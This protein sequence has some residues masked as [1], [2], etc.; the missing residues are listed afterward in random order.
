MNFIYEAS[1]MFVQMDCFANEG[2]FNA[3]L[4]LKL[5]VKMSTVHAQTSHPE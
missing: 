2:R 1:L 3:R 5:F 4:A